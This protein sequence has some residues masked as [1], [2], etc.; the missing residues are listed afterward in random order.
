[1]EKKAKRS[2]ATGK[3]VGVVDCCAEAAIAWFFDFCSLERQRIS[4]EEGNPARLRFDVEGCPNEVVL[5][6][7]K[8]MPFPLT[9]REFVVRQICKPINRDGSYTIITESDDKSVD[10]GSTFN[11]VRGKSMAIFNAKNIKSTTEGTFSQCEV[12]LYQKLDAGGLIPASI[13]NSKL[14]NA[15]S[16]VQDLIDEF[17]KD[18]VVDAIIL[19][20]MASKME[21]GDK[22]EVYSREEDKSFEETVAFFDNFASSFNHVGSPDPLVDMGSIFKDGDSSAIMRA[23]CTVDAAME[24]IGSYEFSLETRSRKERYYNFGG[25]DRGLIRESMHSQLYKVCYE[26]GVPGVYPREWVSR[27]LWKKVDDETML[28][29][30]VDAEVDEYPKKSD[31]VRAKAKTLWEYKKLP[32]LNGVPQT[33][34]SYFTQIGFNGI[35]PKAIANSRGVKLLNY[36][37]NVRERFDRGSEI[38]AMRRKV[39]ERVCEGK[40]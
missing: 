32:N 28:L 40:S 34:V 20:S 36:L 19:N 23:T 13:V 12:T 21:V 9:K 10:Y 6:T 26:F 11:M 38:D 29:V 25:I 4:V 35:I 37:S 31:R 14:P 15:L 16:V 18:A 22:E 30:V 33:R 1:L 2:I 8:S 5:A 3:A 24:E 17:R 7:I 39:S 27:I